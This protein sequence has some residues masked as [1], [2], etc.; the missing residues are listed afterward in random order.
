MPNVNI[1][2]V[3][4]AKFPDGMNT[5]QI[6]S[7]LRQ[8]YSQQAMIGQ[9]DILS[10]QP[11]TVAPYNPSI[12]DKI[13]GG[14]ADTLTS[15][16]LISDNYR[17]QQIG[18]NLSS[19]G[20]L[21]PG[22]GDAT[23]GDEFGRAVAQGD[24]AGMGLGL[25][26]AIPIAGDIAKKGAR[27]YNTIFAGTY[28]DKATEIL[29]YGVKKTSKGEFKANTFG[30]IF[31]SFDEDVASSHG[32]NIQEIKTI[33]HASHDD[34][35]NDV[36][37]NDDIT[38]ESTTNKVKDIFKEHKS[39]GS[40]P[41]DDEVEEI[42][43]YIMGDKLIWDV[44]P[45]MGFERLDEIMLSST[46]EVDMDGVLGDVDWDFQGLKGELGRR[47]GYDSIGM[48]DEHGESVLV[49]NAESIK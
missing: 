42:I 28:G 29:P 14:I 1:K 34:M 11:N 20:E 31:G 40:T 46:S 4:I 17:A 37:F 15:A 41:T 12:V 45:D 21:L 38:W 13:G 26:G 47:M 43:D 19:I 36:F 23:A 39:Y 18:K 32:G 48:P 16:G 9:S 25:L 10:P 27:K 8:K 30:G 22:V 6:R 2:G 49:L 7:F 5:D 24:K 35:R 3:G 33:N 44:E